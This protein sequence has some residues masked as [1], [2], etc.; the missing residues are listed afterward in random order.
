MAIGRKEPRLRRMGT[1]RTAMNV[2][3]ISVSEPGRELATRLPYPRTHG[4]VR[5]AL[6]DNWNDVDGFVMFLSV[7]AAV[8]LIAPLLQSKSTDPAVVCVDDAGRYVVSVCGGHA[9]GGNRLANDVAGYLNAQPIVTTATD[10][11]GLPALDQLEG[12]TPRGEIAAVTSRILAGESL[13][14]ENPL[15]WPLPERLTVLTA[16]N[17]SDD[18]SARVVVTDES[19]PGL[20]S[21]PAPSSLP[22][23]VLHPRSLTLGIGTS[24]DATGADVIEAVETVL[25]TAGLARDS[26]DVISTVDKRR[27]HDAIVELSEHL[28]RPVVSFSPELLSTV[29]VPTPSQTVADAIGTPSVAEAAAVL[30]TKDRSA[31]GPSS[32]GPSSLGLLVKKTVFEKVTVAISRKTHP[33]GVVS[34]VGLGPGSSLDRTPRAERAIRNADVIL[35]YSAYINQCR[36]LI[37]TSQD[38]LTFPLG[39][40]LDRAK[41]AIDYAVEGRRVALVCSGDPGVYAMASP[42]LELLA[43]ST[44]SFGSGADE[45]S[46]ACSVEI[47]PG[48]TASLAAASLLG[49]PLGHDHAAI[50]LSDLLTPWDAIETRLR[51]AI[52][53]DFVLVLYN[54]RSKRRTSQLERV[55][56][57]LLDSRDPNTPVGIV[58]D[59]GR[60]RENAFVTSIRELPCEEVTM[61]TIV[62]VGSSKTSIQGG[63]MVTP[64][65][66]RSEP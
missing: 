60:P 6:K 46:P 26:I 41:A 13:L 32:L 37:S 28:N 3:A 65:G 19:S 5:E 64:R 10:S 7:G 56:E 61:T 52:E 63:L 4:S 59:A 62:I 43:D 18:V 47:V 36:E 45:R 30:A 15:S 1:E 21:P 55:K 20:S 35:G 38:V 54:P 49:A 50:S 39:A 31:L 25:T 29:D 44:G 33:H 23:V 53:A 16:S 48:I 66:Y 11:L 42:L 22:T 40:E 27:A 8:R 12:F 51:A 9:A 34:V 58:T 24:S 14:I 17:G 2:L 57:I